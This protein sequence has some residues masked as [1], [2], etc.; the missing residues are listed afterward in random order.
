MQEVDDKDVEVDGK[1][2]RSMSWMLCFSMQEVDDRGIEVDELKKSMAKTF[3]S[4][5][6]KKT[7][8]WMNWMLHLFS[9]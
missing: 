9:I 7:L 5:S 3:R 1:T 6:W 4:M 2:L 8:K